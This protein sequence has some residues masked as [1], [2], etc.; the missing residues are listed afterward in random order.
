MITNNQKKHIRSLQQKK[1]RNECKEFVAE[2]NTLVTDLIKSNFRM[3]MLISTNKWL[4]SNMHLFRGTDTLLIEVT[5]KE[6]EQLSYMASTAPVIGI[7][8]I[9]EIQLQADILKNSLSIVLDDIKDPGNLGTIIRLADW[10]GIM[11]IVCSKETVDVYNPKVIQATMGSVARVQIFYTELT[12]FLGTYKNKIKVFG[13]FLNGDDIYQKQLPEN[14]LVIIGNE[15]KG[16]SEKILPF[17]DEKILIPPYPLKT[18]SQ[19][20]ESLNASAALAII[21]S[22]FRRRCQT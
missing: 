6:M 16:I 9:P 18:N 14:A 2:G 19:K 5:D 3:V 13:S 8:K 10:F 11:N 21:C 7:F 22:E 20:A 1:F 4:C 17:I 12:E 15:A